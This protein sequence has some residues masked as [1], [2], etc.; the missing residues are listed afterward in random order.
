MQMTPNILNSLIVTEVQIKITM[1]Y[2]FVPIRLA[3]IKKHSHIYVGRDVGNG[4]F[5]YTA[6]WDSDRVTAILEA[7][8]QQLLRF[9]VHILTQQSHFCESIL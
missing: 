1:R 5:S 4:G 7:S 8:K 9:K 6:G 3:K 2:L